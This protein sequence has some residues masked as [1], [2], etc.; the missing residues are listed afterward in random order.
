MAEIR[1]LQ[2]N[3]TEVY[4]VTHEKA[5][6]G[7]D[8]KTINQKYISSIV[9]GED[10]D[11]PE[12]DT[13]EMVNEIIERLDNI[14]NE[15]EEIKEHVE[16][17]T[18]IADKTGNLTDLRTDHKEDIVSAINELKSD[19][20][21]LQESFSN[22][23]DTS[24]YNAKVSELETSINQAFQ[25]GNN[26]KQQLVDAL[27]AKDINVSTNNKFNELITELENFSNSSEGADLPEWITRRWYK[28]YIPLNE[29]LHACDFASAVVGKKIYVFC[30]YNSMNSI[31]L[32]QALCIDT[33]S[34]IYNAITA[35]KNLGSPM[36]GCKAG[37][38][39][40]KIYI[41]GGC[42]YNSSYTYYNTN[43]CY[44]PSTDTYTTK[45]SMPTALGGVGVA[46]SNNRLYVT[47][48][49]GS[50]GY[51]N[52][53]YCYD[54]SSNSWST[55]RTMPTSISH[56]SATT[57]GS[58]IYILGGYGNSEEFYSTN[59]CYNSSSNTY[60]TKKEIPISVYGFGICTYN[61]KIYLSCGDAFYRSD[62]DEDDYYWYYNNF[63]YVYN[64]STNEWNK[65]SMIDIEKNAFSFHSMHAI[66]N[67]M[68]TV[69]GQYYSYEESTYIDYPAL[70]AFVFD[71]ENEDEG[72][73]GA[74]DFSNITLGT[75]YYYL[76]SPY[77]WVDISFNLSTRYRINLQELYNTY[78]NNVRVT[79]KGNPSLITSAAVL[80]YISSD[81]TENNIAYANVYN[82]TVED[83]VIS[84]LTVTSNSI[85]YVIDLTGFADGTPLQNLFVTFSYATNENAI[86]YADDWTLTL[87]SADSSDGSDDGYYVDN[88]LVIMDRTNYNYM[89][90]GTFKTR[91]DMVTYS[92]SNGLTL[93]SLN[94]AYNH[95]YAALQNLII[96]FSLYD[97]LTIYFRGNKTGTY[98]FRAGVSDSVSSSGSGT[99]ILSYNATSAT[100]TTTV[101]STSATSF[102][103][104]DLYNITRK[105]YL[106]IVLCKDS[107]TLDYTSGATIIGVELSGRTWV[108]NGGSGSTTEPLVIMKD[109]YYQTS[110]AFKTTSNYVTHSTSSGLFMKSSNASYHVYAALQYP[111]DLSKYN[112]VKL[113]FKAGVKG[114][115]KFMIGA[116][117]T[118][119]SSGS[120]STVPTFNAGTSEVKTATAY[121]TESWNVYYI[122]ISNLTGTNYLTLVA[123]YD[124]ST[125][126]YNQYGLYITGFEL[127]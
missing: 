76:S 9:Y 3:D 71:E 2:V 94:T 67:V 51:A 89:T 35:K 22:K 5:V 104:I 1:K 79:L 82:I 108:E 19:V 49:E 23:V 114:T 56:H 115:F 11:L 124:T 113:E 43:Y 84:E 88:K 120:A 72:Y 121:G 31:Y 26:V 57:I 105:G 96:D 107:E 80:H 39:N 41:V 119:R 7:S 63:A 16:N 4:P 126:Y 86:L 110:D 13:T 101:S 6:Y 75:G 81:N 59:Y 18:T 50:N 103:H 14:E 52:T 77:N 111:Y 38:I 112:K 33:E 90:E 28:T 93:K 32:D 83:S 122:D 99:G 17:N 34:E 54:P 42:Y 106:S 36:I 91:G 117:T 116:S 20:D 21:D 24:T 58:N 46:V 70:N 109:N 12:V 95:I 92:A 27:I 127:Q 37:A 8:G 87:E 47:G 73:L 78:G 66:D 102:A 25:S 98:K 118:S 53:N 64:P 29:S 65:H 44:D 48:G 97:T 74:V 15:L 40:D 61:D 68:Y 30:G 123:V 60:S 10:V 85:S 100:T 45:R 69:M 55:K 62:D 125:V